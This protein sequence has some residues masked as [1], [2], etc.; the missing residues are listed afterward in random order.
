MSTR[1]NDSPRFDFVISDIADYEDA[2]SIFSDTYDIKI[3]EILRSQLQ[4]AV[5][6]ELE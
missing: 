6:N 5:G 4:R 3:R 2:F 1:I